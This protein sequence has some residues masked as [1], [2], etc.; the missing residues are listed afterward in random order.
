MATDAPASRSGSPVRWTCW[1]EAA[2][3][4][5]PGTNQ[6][7]PSIKSLEQNGGPIRC[8]VFFLFIRILP[9]ILKRFDAER[10]LAGGDSIAICPLLGVDSLASA[11]PLGLT[12]LRC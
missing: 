12:P 2:L 11:N 5:R 7:E 10:T 1:K 9:I 8:R 3:R 4:R 6:C